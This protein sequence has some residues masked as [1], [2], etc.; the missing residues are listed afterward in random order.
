SSTH[1]PAFL[2][3]DDARVSERMVPPAESAAAPSHGPPYSA[4]HARAAAVPA[5]HDRG[6]KRISV[7]GSTGSIGTQALDVARWRGYRVVGLAAGTNVDLLVHQAREFRPEL[8]ACT[9]EVA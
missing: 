3:P 8:V 6:M 2:P 4:S 7:L 1:L 5:W 9:A